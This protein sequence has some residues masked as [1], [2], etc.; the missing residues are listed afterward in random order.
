MQRNVPY[1]DVQCPQIR[2]LS[3][4]I[5]TS[6]PGVEVGLRRG[7]YSEDVIGTASNDGD[8]DDTYQIHLTANISAWAPNGVELLPFGLTS[9][10]T[11]MVMENWMTE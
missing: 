3:S 1:T 6:P 8:H 2:S 11:A 7:V 5:E 10:D 4:T 9:L